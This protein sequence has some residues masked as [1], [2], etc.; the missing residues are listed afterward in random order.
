MSTATMDRPA[1]DFQ[2][3]K[4]A[5]PIA[6]AGGGPR[7]LDADNRTVEAAIA[8]EALVEVFDPSSWSVI[9]ERRSSA[10]QSATSRPTAR[11]V[12]RASR[13]H[14]RCRACKWCGSMTWPRSGRF[15]FCLRRPEATT[16]FGRPSALERPRPENRIGFDSSCGA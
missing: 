13:S 5:L 2:T 12:Q 6:P 4:F 14:W 9:R 1:T 15:W 8:S 16:S 10:K 11:L 3:R 7:S